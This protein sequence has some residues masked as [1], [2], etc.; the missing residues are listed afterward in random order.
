M[1]RQEWVLAVAPATTREETASESCITEGPV[2]RTTGILA[3]SRLKTMAVNGADHLADVLY[4]SLIGVNPRWLNAPKG[5]E[6][7]RN[8]P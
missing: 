1:G 4:A 5:D 8:G 3:Y 2:T 6:L 7:P